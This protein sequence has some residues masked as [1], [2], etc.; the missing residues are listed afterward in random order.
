MSV[1]AL[2]RRLDKVTAGSLRP[3]VA[4][5]LAM[6]RFEAAIKQRN[7]MDRLW[8]IAENGATDDDLEWLEQK[9]KETG[10][11]FHEAVAACVKLVEDY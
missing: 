1:A 8:H 2:G 10:F 4:A 9:T 7:V 3:V 5:A 11:D 6:R